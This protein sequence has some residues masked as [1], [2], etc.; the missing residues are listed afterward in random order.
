MTD[1]MTNPFTTTPPQK[2]DAIL[3]F[4][5]DGSAEVMLQGM[6]PIAVMN[7]LDTGWMSVT[8]RALAFL[9]LHNDP[10]AQKLIETMQSELLA[11]MTT[12]HA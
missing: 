11:R 12:V 5:Q 10:Q 9:Y 8:L 2:G 1:M 3:I 7:Q 6:E 4:R